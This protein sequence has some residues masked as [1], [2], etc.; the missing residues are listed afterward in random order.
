MMMMMMIII[1]LWL[2]ACKAATTLQPGDPQ[3]IGCWWLGYMVVA[4]GLL[5]TSVP[6][7]FFPSSM[8]QR[9]QTPPP[10]I[11]DG[12]NAH[13]HNSSSSSSRQKSIT[14]KLR[15]EIKGRPTRCLVLVTACSVLV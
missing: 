3:W 10:S 8:I 14:R 12:V 2:C 7:W 11:E 5:A 4:V 9:Q 13:A 6:L 15:K 1:V